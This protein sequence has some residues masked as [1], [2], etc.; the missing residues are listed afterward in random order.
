[1]NNY[2]VAYCI[3]AVELKHGELTEILET[4]V[5]KIINHKASFLRNNFI[6]KI[7]SIPQAP[8][9]S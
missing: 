2:H 7:L 3:H 8:L 4:I 5:L 1:M 6:L 9:R